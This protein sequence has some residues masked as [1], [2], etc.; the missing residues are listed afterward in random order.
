MMIS[1]SCKHAGSSKP[2]RTGKA[3]SWNV[4]RGQ[5][6]KE[7]GSA[8]DA[9]V[10]IRY[11][12]SPDRLPGFQPTNEEKINDYCDAVESFLTSDIFKTYSFW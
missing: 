6:R 5:S 2:L 9:Y 3:I 10:S 1:N 12:R 7:E 4:T 11:G 8:I